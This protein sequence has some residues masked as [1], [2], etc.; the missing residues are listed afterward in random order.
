MPF[1]DD[2]RTIPDE[3]RYELPNEGQ[4]IWLNDYLNTNVVLFTQKCHL[5]MQLSTIV[6]WC[7]NTGSQEIKTEK[8]Q[9]WSIWKSRTAGM[10]RF[11]PSHNVYINDTISICW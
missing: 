5:Y 11:L 7:C 2:I 1:S 4:V 9:R 3:A 6:G 10:Q 8:L